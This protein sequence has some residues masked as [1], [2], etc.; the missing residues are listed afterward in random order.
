[1]SSTLKKLENFKQK[2]FLF[3]IAGNEVP[4]ISK[5]AY[6]MPDM[7]KVISKISLGVYRVNSCLSQSGKVSTP[8]LLIY[9]NIWSRAPHTELELQNQCTQLEK[10]KST[11]S[12]VQKDLVER[13]ENWIT[14][15]TRPSRHQKKH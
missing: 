7:W 12:S 9:A 15:V 8:E 4:Q 14:I 2:A 10:F 6:Y 13:H 1:M 11:N 5:Y 3:N